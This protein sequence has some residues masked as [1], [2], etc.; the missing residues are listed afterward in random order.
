MLLARPDGFEPPTTWFEWK[1]RY[2][3]VFENQ[4]LAALAMLE[5]SLTKTQ[6]WHTQSGHD[7]FLTHTATPS[8]PP[9]AR[10]NRSVRLMSVQFHLNP[11]FS[12]RGSVWL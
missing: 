3:Y 9:I 12:R 11:R 10:Q 2:F 6:L 1:T 5:P 7:T 8:T 4:S